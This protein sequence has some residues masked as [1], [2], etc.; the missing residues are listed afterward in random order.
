M[1][2]P[3]RAGTPPNPH[4]PGRGTGGTAGEAEASEWQVVSTEETLACCRRGNRGPKRLACPQPLSDPS[5]AVRGVAPRGSQAG[6]GQG[7]NGVGGQCSFGKAF[8]SRPLHSLCAFG[9]ITVILP[10]R[11]LVCETKG[12]RPDNQAD[13]RAA[14]SVL[15]LQEEA[16]PAG[17]GQRGR[18]ASPHEP[19]QGGS[20]PGES[21]RPVPEL[22][23][24]GQVS[25]RLDPLGAPGEEPGHFLFR[26]C[27]HHA[28]R[29]AGH[30]PS[31]PPQFT[32]GLVPPLGKLRQ[33][34]SR[35]EAGRGPTWEGDTGRTDSQC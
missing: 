3:Q 1:R 17:P 18:R 25:V 9:E 21:R 10:S 11:S 16:P 24:P 12:C 23:E 6:W 19:T 20:H 8:E 29:L 32:Q 30:L 5:Q 26:A 15:G 13:A 31:Q 33:G 7:R 35:E 14:A 4:F 22:C 27:P 2:T 28:G 34:C